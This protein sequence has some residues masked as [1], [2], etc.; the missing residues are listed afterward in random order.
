MTSLRPIYRTV[1]WTVQE[2]RKDN[3]VAKRFCLLQ[4][5]PLCDQIDRREVFGGRKEVRNWSAT[6]CRQSQHGFQSPTDRRSVVDWS[7]NSLRP[8]CYCKHAFKKQSATDRQSVADW[9]PADRGPVGNCSPVTWPYDTQFSTVTTFCLHSKHFQIDKLSYLEITAIEQKY[10]MEFHGTK[11]YFIWRYQSYKEFHGILHLI[12][13]NTCVIW[14]GALLIPWNWNS[15]IFLFGDSRV[16]LNSME[17][18]MKIQ[19]NMVLNKRQSHSSMEVHGTNWYFIS[20]HKSSMEFPG[21]FHGI[22]W[23]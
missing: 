22:P 6:G 4:V 1:A 16:P 18:P 13:W 2:G 19:V 7:P 12:P 21:I 20:R 14:N 3:L 5:K 10:S 17:Y 15:V 9:S 8:F 23:N 11:L